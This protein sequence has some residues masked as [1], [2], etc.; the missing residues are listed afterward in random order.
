[1]IR[2]PNC[3]A[4]YAETLAACP[5]CAA[6]TDQEVRCAR[7][8]EAFSGEDACPYCGLL[9]VD[10][11]CN[12]HPSKRAVAR[13]VLCGDALC[14]V[15]ED[16]EK[17]V[18]LCPSH[19]EVPIV[20]G[21]AQVYSTTS[22]LE[23]QLLRENLRSEEIEAQVYSQKDMMFNVDLGELSIVRLLVPVWQYEQAL[24]VIREHMDAGGAVTF[25]CSACGEPFTPGARECTACGAAL[26]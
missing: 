3:E 26:V 7:C 18:S 23:A 10:A 17:H 25:A 20:Q 6:V 21:W 5:N 1:M 14:P 11:A 9:R 4:E 22:E 24:G 12:R 13:C 16:Q 15:C 19:R 8:G 2:C